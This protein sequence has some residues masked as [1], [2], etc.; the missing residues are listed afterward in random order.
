MMHNYTWYVM[1]VTEIKNVNKLE[2]NILFTRRKIMTTRKIHLPH[3]QKPLWSET[4]VVYYGWVVRLAWD[5]CYFATKEIYLGNRIW[6]DCVLTL[7]FQWY[8]FCVLGLCYIKMLNSYTIY[9]YV[10]KD[11]NKTEDT[12]KVRDKICWY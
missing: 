9:V 5:D 3:I 4:H 8:T 11:K 7:K 12:Q 2:G 6:N 1:G 10:Y